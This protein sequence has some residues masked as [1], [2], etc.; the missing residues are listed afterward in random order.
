GCIATG[1][2][3]DGDSDCRRRPGRR[4]VVSNSEIA[5]NVRGAAFADEVEADG[6]VRASRDR[7]SA[8]DHVGIREELVVDGHLLVGA[9]TAFA[10]SENLAC[11]GTEVDNSSGGDKLAKPGLDGADTVGL[12]RVEPPSEAL[13]GVE[14][15]ENGWA[16]GLRGA[17]ASD[18]LTQR[19]DHR[20]I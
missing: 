20:R 10:P 16:A 12:A 11:V 1:A 2:G 3:L 15:H 14:N 13:E 19:T 9:A 5:E 17:Q 6:C 7:H 18:L 4:G 8:E